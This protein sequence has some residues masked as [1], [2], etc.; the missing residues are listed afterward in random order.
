[1]SRYIAI[2]IGVLFPLWAS[3]GILHD[4]WNHPD[5][6]H[7]TTLLQY[8]AL[9]PAEI[10][11]SGP[12]TIYAYNFAQ[13]G[14]V[15]YAQ[16][17]SEIVRNHFPEQK[18]RVI[19]HSDLNDID[20]IFRSVS[21]AP[22][23]EVLF[24]PQEDPS[25]EA[26]IDAWL[27]EASIIFS[28][29]TNLPN[30]F[31]V[32]I[33][34]LSARLEKTGKQV[35]TLARAIAEYREYSDI[36][37]R[38]QIGSFRLDFFEGR[39]DIDSSL[40]E[41]ADHILDPTVSTIDAAKDII[42]KSRRPSPAIKHTGSGFFLAQITS[43]FLKMGFSS[44]S[45]GMLVSPLIAKLLPISLES[46]IFELPEELRKNAPEVAQLLDR[47]AYS[48]STGYRF[49]TAYMHNIF[50][51]V[52]YI[53]TVSYLEP[54]STPVILS[55][56]E[57]Y[58]FQTTFFE[59][60]MKRFG[61][62]RIRYSNLNT[63]EEDLFDFG[64]PEGKAVHIIYLPKI[65]DDMSYYSLFA[66]SANPVGVTGNQS[67][68]SAITLRKIPFY[69]SHYSSHRTIAPYLATFDDSHLL[70]P[71]FLNSSAPQEVAHVISRYSYLG[72]RWA[73]NI[74]AKKNANDLINTYVR[75]STQPDAEIEALIRKIKA[76]S[77]AG[78]EESDDPVVNDA[79]LFKHLIDNYNNP[80]ANQ[81]SPSVNTLVVNILHVL[82]Q[83]KDPDIR[84]WLLRLFI[85]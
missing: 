22:E 71:V 20:N 80:L 12:V 18:I 11:S 6:A 35:E 36:E 74:L 54:D 67:L 23:A 42:K 1:M 39:V 4:E 51:I 49:Y 62:G 43:F 60:F 25:G 79:L 21:F 56:F 55:N 83:I 38:E 26:R 16:T 68:F 32:N 30:R 50:S 72:Q 76:L 27:D 75:L 70:S 65:K 9:R 28:I 15:A 63:Q 52:G 78:I 14:Y 53:A 29:G 64:L 13:L 48:D 2:I 57:S 17:I 47:E 7:K 85:Q 69:E 33:V 61:I 5:K 59:T 37:P 19:I 44:S 41:Q 40:I 82:Q 10:K 66:M 84:A 3:A 34:Q 81:L 31:Y 77:A 46:P 8:L 24:V 73:N 45:A 58:I